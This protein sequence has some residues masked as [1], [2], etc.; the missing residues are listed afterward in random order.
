MSDISCFGHCIPA[1]YSKFNVPVDFDAYKQWRE[2]ASAGR[3]NGP[4]GHGVVDDDARLAQ[5]EV[6]PGIA[7][8]TPN[9]PG[10]VAGVAETGDDGQGA[11]PYPTSFAQIVDLISSGKPIPG[12][13]EIPDTVLD[14]QGT[15]SKREKRRKPWEKDTG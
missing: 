6:L 13:K 1:P 9:R 11:A 15:E 7:P 12:I 4:S 5:G 10:T 2:A 14:G 8:F 3:S